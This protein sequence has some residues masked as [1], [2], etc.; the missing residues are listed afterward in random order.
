MDSESL[1]VLNQYMTIFLDFYSMKGLWTS[2]AYNPYAN[3][4]IIPI[5]SKLSSVSLYDK[6]RIGEGTN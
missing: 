5:I 3:D 6:M 2:Y 4:V 1:L